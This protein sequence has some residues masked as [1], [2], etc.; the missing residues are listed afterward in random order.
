VHASIDRDPYVLADILFSTHFFFAIRNF[1]FTFQLAGDL[2]PSLQDHVDVAVAALQL[3]QVT[4]R[5]LPSRVSKDSDFAI[6]VLRSGLVKYEDLSDLK[7]EDAKVSVAVMKA[8]LVKYSD[9]ETYQKREK[10]VI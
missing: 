9:L 4:F 10:E 2:L 6:A 3:Q 8:K 5:D 1:F 7:K